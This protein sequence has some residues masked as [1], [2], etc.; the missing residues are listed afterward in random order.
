[1]RFLNHLGTEFCIAH[2]Q[3]KTYKWFPDLV[4]QINRQ[5]VTLPDDVE[6]VTV[7]NHS[8]TSML[9][10]Q[11]SKNGIPFINKVP[12]GS[13]W[14]NLKKIGYINE[15]LQEVKSKYV[16]ILD[17][18][19]VLVTRS[20]NKIV[21]RFNKHG[22]Q[23][24]FC[25]DKYNYPDMLIDK[26]PD[27]DFRGEYRYLNAGACFG[28]LEACKDFY[29]KADEILRN[30]NIYNPSNSEQFIIRYTF[31]DVT[32]IV[33]FDYEC[34]IFQSFIGAVIKDLGEKQ[35]MII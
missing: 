20:V 28:F 6:I 15:A 9:I 19:D 16:L 30:E 8:S 32:N 12:E 29:R 7:C 10:N 18:S 22:K 3:G 27:R 4:K 2:F 14:N 5:K 1:M 35:Y 33:D 34:S 25:A 23:I 26:I 31:K 24:L 11:L 17:A 21:K 13:Y